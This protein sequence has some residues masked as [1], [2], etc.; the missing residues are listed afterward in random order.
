MLRNIWTKR[1]AITFD[2]G[3][4]GI[5]ALQ[6]RRSNGHVHCSDALHIDH[7]GASESEKPDGPTVDVAQ[8]H[9]LIGQ[10]SFTGSDVALVLSP[11]EARFYPLKLPDQV[12][13][14]PSD[15]IL[16]ALRWEVAREGRCAAE[17][18]EARYWRLPGGRAL[19]ANVMAVVISTKQAAAWCDEFSQ[20]RLN[21]SRIDVTPCALV[22]SA[23]AHWTPQVNDLWGILDL[24]LRHS[25]LT[26][27]AHETP[28]YVR[29]LSGSLDDWTRK[30]ARAFEATLDVAEDLKRAHGVKAAGRV[31]GAPSET[32]SPLGAADLP[33]AVASVFREPLDTLMDEIGR[34]FS[35]VMQDF[36]EHAVRTLFLAGGGAQL[37]GL[38]PALERELGITIQTLGKAPTGASSPLSASETSL[39]PNAAAAAGA[40]LLDLE[41]A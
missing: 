38:I 25:T 27:V 40:A 41:A 32:R 15:R 34:C 11:L 5:R 13:T 31:V 7:P 4:S 22:R 8:I 24:G 18:V 35:F 17:D 36:P 2:L 12:L 19:Q 1:S 9:R 3:A 16:Q 29:T 6:L 26:I 14:Q 39:P 10:G 28:T 30:L 20:H 33:G 23:R 37:P 21:L